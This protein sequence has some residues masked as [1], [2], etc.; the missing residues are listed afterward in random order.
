MLGQKRAY[1]RNIEAGR[2]ARFKVDL[3]GPTPPP[4]KDVLRLI[5][6]GPIGA[7]HFPDHAIWIL[8][9]HLM[10]KDT[11]QGGLAH[12]R[13]TLH[14]YRTP[15]D[16]DFALCD[17]ERPQ[18]VKL[19]VPADKRI[20]F[21]CQG[22][23]ARPRAFKEIDIHD[24]VHVRRAAIAGLRRVDQR[25]TAL[26][27]QACTAINSRQRSFN[28]TSSSPQLPQQRGAG[29]E[30]YPLLLRRLRCESV[31]HALCL[32]GLEQCLLVSEDLARSGV[33]VGPEEGK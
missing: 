23:R 29:G 15:T 6:A 12:A 27:V 8:R 20:L 13:H 32:V 3:N 7:D 9:V 33:A 17:E 19:L 18:F 2:I 28:G 4:I 1:I 5:G 30:E 25:C 16:G 22:R 31:E 21:H 11:G 24:V 10:R 26:R 14:P